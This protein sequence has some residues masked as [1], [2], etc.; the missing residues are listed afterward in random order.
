VALAVDGLP[1]GASGTFSPNPATTASTLNV[2]ITS[3]TPSGSYVLTITGTSG[4]L[5]HSTTVTLFVADFS[6][7]ASPST[8]SLA[9]GG[10]ATYT[11]TINSMDGFSGSVTLSVSGL[12]PKTSA[13][14]SPNPA[15]GSSTLTI[16]TN[17][18]QTPPGSYAVVISGT[19]SGV[20]HTV[21]VTLVVT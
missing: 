19:S 8:V 14:F 6:L 12:P 1:V 5:S 11:V 17:R 13:S 20:T 18:G 10:R 21:T 2:N 7:S 15:T 4:V 9:A 16:R 3:I